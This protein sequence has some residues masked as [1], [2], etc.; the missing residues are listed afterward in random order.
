M[1]PGEKALDALADLATAMEVA[2][3]LKARERFGG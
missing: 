3:S 1:S 2:G